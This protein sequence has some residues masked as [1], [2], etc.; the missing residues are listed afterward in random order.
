MTIR[1]PWNMRGDLRLVALTPHEQTYTVLV[2]CTTA[3]RS[4]HTVELVAELSGEEAA[5]IIT[6]Q[7]DTWRAVNIPAHDPA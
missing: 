3:P 5:Q 1:M 2:L 6:A 7:V 4:S